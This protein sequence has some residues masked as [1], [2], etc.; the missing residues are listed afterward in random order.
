M[1]VSCDNEFCIYQ[2]QGGCI[3]EQVQLDIQGNCTNCMYIR[4]E[5]ETLRELKQKL[6]RDY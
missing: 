1:Q 3:L 2:A 5:D 4:V 6:L